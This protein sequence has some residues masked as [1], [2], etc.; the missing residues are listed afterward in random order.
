ME[1]ADEMAK[2]ASG[3]WILESVAIDKMEDVPFKNDE[4][5]STVS[6]NTSQKSFARNASNVK[7]RNRFPVPTVPK[8]E[9]SQSSATKGLKT[10]RFI[11]RITTGKEGEAWRSVE[12]R[13]HQ[14][15]TDWRLP[16]DKF[17]VCI[18]NFTNFSH[19]YTFLVFENIQSEIKK[20][21]RTFFS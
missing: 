12:K 4:Q 6:R 1:N 18:G 11:D 8:M 15:A 13:F 3:R 21:L 19:R 7:N 2:G 16:R 17:G 9:R 5:P 10:L 20:F 14:L